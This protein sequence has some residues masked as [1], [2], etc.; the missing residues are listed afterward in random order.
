MFGCSYTSVK[1]A[2]FAHD[3]A[4]IYLIYWFSLR[5]KREGIVTRASIKDSEVPI[6]TIVYDCTKQDKK[7]FSPV[8]SIK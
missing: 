6:T 8:E 3:I 2:Y 5:E 1:N 7:M 4:S